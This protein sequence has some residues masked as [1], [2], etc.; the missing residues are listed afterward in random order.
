MFLRTF[1]LCCN[2]LYCH[3][4]LP[5]GGGERNKDNI[6]LTAKLVEVAATSTFIGNRMYLHFLKKCHLLIAHSVFGNT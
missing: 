1:S 4:V 5:G 2:K 6:N 3:S